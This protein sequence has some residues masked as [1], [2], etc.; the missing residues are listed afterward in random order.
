M[1]K[2]RYPQVLEDLAELG[3]EAVPEYKFH[4]TRK[5][6]FDF[7]IIGPKIGIEID[8]GIFSGGR[9]TRGSGFVKDME[10][11][12]EAAILGWRIL[13]FQPKEAERHLIA[14]TVFRAMFQPRQP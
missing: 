3:I 11:L 1:D 5:W 8:G 2:Q 14:G 7:A 4:P 9:H 10:K 13:R 6:Q 12:N